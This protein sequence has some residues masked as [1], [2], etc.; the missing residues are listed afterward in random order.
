MKLQKN[1]RT[2]FSSIARELGVS[3]GIVRF[4]VKKMID[5]GVITKFTALLDSRKIGLSIIAIIM[6][7]I[8]PV[9][10]KEASMKISDLDETYHIFE[11]TGDYDIVTVVHTRDMKHLSD[12]KKRIERISGIRGV[13]VSACTR[14][15]KIKTIFNL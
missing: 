10:F 2:S 8:D 1:S 3:E 6:V 13:M 14:L 11:S 15:I 9:F 12:L 5:S 7:K 4:R